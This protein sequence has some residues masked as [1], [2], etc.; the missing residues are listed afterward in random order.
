MH[1]RGELA[2][3]HFLAYGAQGGRVAVFLLVLGNHVIDSLL[4]WCEGLH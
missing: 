4:L 1:P 3:A 2:D